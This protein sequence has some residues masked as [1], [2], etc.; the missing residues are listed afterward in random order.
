MRSHLKYNTGMVFVGILKAGNEPKKKKQ[1]WKKDSVRWYG[2]RLV[3]WPFSNAKLYAGQ[4]RYGSQ[5]KITK[6]KVFE[7]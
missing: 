7:Y 3:W 5:K 1:V 2:I 6:R 4:L